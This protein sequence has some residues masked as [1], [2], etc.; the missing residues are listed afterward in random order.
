[1]NPVST[2]CIFNE[3][4]DHHYRDLG[5]LFVQ[6]QE[7]KSEW[8]VEYLETLPAF[9]TLLKK[10]PIH[11][12]IFIFSDKPSQGVL[13]LI[14][15]NRNSTHLRQTEMVAIHKKTTPEG[16]Q[17]TL[18][19]GIRTLFS[20]P[21]EKKL[22]LL[23]LRAAADAALPALLVGADFDKS[24]P[25]VFQ[26]EVFG[27][28]GKVLLSPMGDLQVETDVRFTEGNLVT[29][30]SKIAKDLGMAKFHFHVASITSEDT[31]YHYGYSYRLT[32]D[33]DT[34]LRVQLKS[35]MD[36]HE[37]T[38][39]AH[40]KTKVLWIGD[41]IS[42]DVENIFDKTVFSVHL[43][44][45]G[46]ATPLLLSNM[47]PKVLIVGNVPEPTLRS[48]QSWLEGK[49]HGER[50]VFTTSKGHPADWIRLHDISPE[51]FQAT[52]LTLVRPFLHRRLEHSLE[53]ARYMS[54]KSDYSRC[55]FPIEGKVLRKSEGYLE[56]ELAHILD[57]GCV[58][59]AYKPLATYL[60]VVHVEAFLNKSTFHIICEY[61]PFTGQGHAHLVK[62]K[63][64]SDAPLPA[65]PRAKHTEV[66]PQ[67]VEKIE[68]F[69]LQAKPFWM[70][71]GKVLIGLAV[72]GFVGAVLYWIA[73]K[74]EIVGRDPATM[75]DTLKAIRNA[76][77]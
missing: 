57:K 34:R 14:S 65:F 24:E 7:K 45:S 42:S 15:K 54:R 76:F 29:L 30:R 53:N 71:L 64:F 72:A 67:Q 21:I 31:Y 44:K 4:K 26:G 19:M 68:P 13:D 23:R 35:W 55:S 1:M 60:K 47:N 51:A 46:R 32:F 74:S 58:F 16:I 12:L 5:A 41:S 49:P 39:F 37:Q 63:A 66:P 75:G 48:I 28:I 11:F 20:E 9:D 22:I 2:L 43:E 50:V 59:L 40:P 36:T 8:V 17:K 73:P 33:A 77:Q 70:D 62:N 3:A 6:E 18:M 38:C 10:K 52:F 25:V 27:R 61:V 56:L 69:F